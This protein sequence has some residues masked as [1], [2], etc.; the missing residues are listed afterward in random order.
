MGPDG[1]PRASSD[2]GA[3]R[4]ARAIHL[5]TG[6]LIGALRRGS[7]ED[8]R[9]RQGLVRG[10]AVGSSAVNWTEFLCGPVQRHAIELAARVVDEPVALL[11]VDA[12][13][14]AKLFNLG[15][16]RRGSLNDC[17]I[18]ATALRAN[19]SLATTNPADLRGAHRV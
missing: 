10:E 15:R 19:A 18:A 2:I 14:A 7:A 3:G 16:R 13:A 4:R 11:A 17:M 9:L 12:A 5:D 6:F 8:E 1:P